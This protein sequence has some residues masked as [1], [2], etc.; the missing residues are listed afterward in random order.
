MAEAMAEPKNKANHTSTRRV[1]NL[2]LRR[3]CMG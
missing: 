1:M 2:A 3:F